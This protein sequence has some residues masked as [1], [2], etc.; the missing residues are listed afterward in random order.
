MSDNCVENYYKTSDLSLATTISL[1]FPI[2]A[3]E[4]DNPH[5][6]VFLFDPTDKLTEFID[7]YWKKE[8]RVEP[9]QFA[10]QIKNLK[11]RIYSNE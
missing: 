11:T 10:N 2:V 6:V 9:Q 7:S 1:N 8:V 4:K 5:R 3:I